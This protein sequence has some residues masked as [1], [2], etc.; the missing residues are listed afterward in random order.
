MTP[1]EEERTRPAPERLVA[2]MTRIA[3][4]V[5]QMQAR[6][7]P[8]YDLARERSRIVAAAYKA[9]GSPRK[10]GAGMAYNPLRVVPVF[11]VRSGKTYHTEPATQADKDA[12][13]SWVRERD[14]LRREL[15]VNRGRGRLVA[16]SD[17]TP[18]DDGERD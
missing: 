3:E 12:W 8:Y 2:S 14:H 1:E 17:L 13:Y 15:G 9:A 11:T 5:T 4:A 6:S 7:G 10:V 18:S 16:D